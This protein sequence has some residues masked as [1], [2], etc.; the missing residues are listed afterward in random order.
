ME[1]PSRWP[2]WTIG[3]PSTISI[4][5]WKPTKSS[6]RK[7]RDNDREQFGNFVEYE[8]L[9]GT[10][11][12]RAM[13]PFAPHFEYGGARGELSR[14]LRSAVSPVVDVR[15]PVQKA[16]ARIAARSELVFG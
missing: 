4:S 13:Q 9:Y 12:E 8:K 15:D 3:T 5:N 1:N 14:L 6:L 7:A 16:R 10:G 11:D 2:T